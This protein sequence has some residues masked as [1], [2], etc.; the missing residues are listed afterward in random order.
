[1]QTKPRDKDEHYYRRQKG[2]DEHFCRSCG[3]V[4]KI[5]AEICPKC[6]VRQEPEEIPRSK[7]KKSR[8]TAAVLGILLGGFGI[9]KFYIGKT[10]LGFLYLIFFWTSI[11]A[12]IGLIEGILYLTSTKNDKE[13]NAKYVN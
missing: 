5:E 9:H 12:I 1:M 8:V 11:P 7:G 3:E 13:F 6:G 10:G 2:S 4:I